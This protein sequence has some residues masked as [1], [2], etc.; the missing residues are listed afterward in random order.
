MASTANAEVEKTEATM[1]L[2]NSD[3]IRSILKVD[4]SY[5]ALN[6]L[7]KVSKA[8]LLTTFLVLT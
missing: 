6:D 3:I 2:L 7:I 4:P 8:Y 1:D 5:K